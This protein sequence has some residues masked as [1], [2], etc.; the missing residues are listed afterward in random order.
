MDVDPAI[1]VFQWPIVH[2]ANMAMRMMMGS[3]TP[4]KNRS[5]ERM[6]FSR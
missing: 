3:G 2:R 4:S 6:V 5:I 1:N